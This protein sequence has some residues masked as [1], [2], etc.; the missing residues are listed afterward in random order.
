MACPAFSPAV[1]VGQSLMAATIGI[2]T[3]QLAA[4]PMKIST[5]IFKP[6]MKPTDSRAGLRLD[7]K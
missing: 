6:T 2:V 5:A 3:S 7:P 1:C 4:P